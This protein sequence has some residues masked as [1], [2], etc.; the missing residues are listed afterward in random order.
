MTSGLKNSNRQNKF[1][2]ENITIDAKHS[3]MISHFKNLKDSI[4]S[5]KDELKK[6][7]S[8]YNN[9][10][11][12]RKN[13]I[14]YILY[15]NEIRE[16]INEIK[17]KIQNI[18]SNND[19]NKY[20]LDVGVLLHNYYENIENSKTEDLKSANFEDNLVN[21]DNEDDDLSDIENDEDENENHIEK[22]GI[23]PVNN[24][25]NFFNNTDSNKIESG[26]NINNIENNIEHELSKNEGVYT[27]T[28]ISDFVKHEATFKKKNILD[29]YLQKIDVNYISR[30]KIDR[31]IC[32]CPNCKTEM[33]LYP[34]DGLQICQKC[35]LQQNILIESDKPS[36]KD[37]PLEVC[38]FSYKRINHFNESLYTT[39]NQLMN[40]II[41][42]KLYFKFLIDFI[43]YF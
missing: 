16:K 6:L 28:K 15:R 14:D 17:S 25:L 20:Y 39:K 12:S 35:G 34:S 11:P 4:P 37:P 30:I 23:K 42:Y 40:G 24:I 27:S 1:P 38:Y 36:F 8:S 3:E 7:V 2:N 19:M 9:K 5:L 32:N 18:S 31:D 33:V 43:T 22:N 29:E 10:D 21:F 26:S 13:D 41:F